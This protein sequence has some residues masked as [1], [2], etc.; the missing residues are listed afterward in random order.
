[1]IVPAYLKPVVE[2]LQEHSHRFVPPSMQMVM[3]Q[4]IEK[5]YLY[6]HINNCL[7]IAE[8]RYVLF[9]DEFKKHVNYMNLQ[10]LPFGSFHCIAFFNQPT[11]PAEEIAFIDKLQKHGIKA[12]S[13][14]KCIIGE[15]KK[16]G[17]IFGYSAARPSLI[18]QKILVMGSLTQRN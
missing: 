5:N 13:L 18:K 10:E 15:T 8:E 2:A 4:F 3:Q 11:S 17:L 12:L 9:K 1:M 16:T 14:S 7:E 6:Q